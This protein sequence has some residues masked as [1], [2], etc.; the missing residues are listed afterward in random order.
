M[1]LFLRIGLLVNT[2]ILLISAALFVSGSLET[3]PTEE[4]IEAGRLVWGGLV[5][6]FLLIEIAL[7]VLLR[8]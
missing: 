4:Q 5:G 7:I 3:F 1:Q 2:L 8:R 6:L